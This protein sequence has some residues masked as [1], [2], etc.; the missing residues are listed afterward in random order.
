MFSVQLTD[1][2]GT[3]A[4]SQSSR[5]DGNVPSNL[6]GIALVVAATILFVA[7]AGTALPKAVKA[8][9]GQGK[10]P[11]SLLACALALNTA[12]LLFTWR[13]YH[14]MA[15]EV[16]FQRDAEALARKLADTDALTGCLNR[17]SI[18]SAAAQL[19]ADAKA[20]GRGIV[21]LMID[22][23]NFKQI[24]DANGH[25]AGDAILREAAERLGAILPHDSLL[26]RLGGDEFTCILVHD[27]K[28]P[29]R[30]DRLTATIIA[31]VA[32]PFFH[33]EQALE[34]TVS[35]GIA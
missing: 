27:P 5:H 23:D 16:K 26:A 20:R 3:G 30:I 9:A 35:V 31:A 8:L 14:A 4:R 11:N 2:S 18:G 1:T 29:D 22:I 32:R 28:A 19:M 33:G 12:L 17:R 25:Q 15:D 13:R 7:A 34:T 6:L 24:N 10:G 21:A